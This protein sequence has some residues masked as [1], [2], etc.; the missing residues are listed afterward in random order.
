MLFYFIG[1]GGCVS[2][3][4]RAENFLR[5]SGAG[6]AD[7]S[8]VCQSAW[9]PN[10]PKRNPA[11]LLQNRARNRQPDFGPGPFAL[12]PVSMSSSITDAAIASSIDTFAWV[13]APERRFQE[14]GTLLAV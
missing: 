1:V 10:F 12:I 14:M 7:L 8:S 4:P 2:T 13:S 9:N 5:G 3:R 11:F 6:W